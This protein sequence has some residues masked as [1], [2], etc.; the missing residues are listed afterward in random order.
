MLGTSSKQG[1]GRGRPPEP[2]WAN[3]PRI[4]RTA[5]FAMGE[6]IRFRGPAHRVC[7]RMGPLAREPCSP[8][9]A[10]IDASSGSG[11][12]D[13]P[14]WHSERELRIAFRYKANSSMTAKIFISIINNVWINKKYNYL[15]MNHPCLLNLRRD[16]SLC[17]ILTGIPLPSSGYS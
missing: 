14:S 8:L 11:R 2:P 16:N 5:A 3:A 10:D 9:P 17:C 15:I 6:R 1:D 7:T 13:R 4:R 12:R